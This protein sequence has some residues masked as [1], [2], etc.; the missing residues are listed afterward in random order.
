MIF[1]P[2]AVRVGVGYHFQG[3]TFR[4]NTYFFSNSLRTLPLARRSIFWRSDLLSCSYIYAIFLCDNDIRSHGLSSNRDIS[5][6]DRRQ[7][8]FAARITSRHLIHDEKAVPQQLAES[9]LN[10][11]WSVT[12]CQPGM[13][14]A[15]SCRIMIEKPVD[16][17]DRCRTEASRH[18]ADR[19]RLRAAPGATSGVE[20]A[21]ARSGAGCDLFAAMHQTL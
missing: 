1:T 6:A 20:R 13:K 21:G 18:A 10:R 2:F 12:R 9:D 16:D 5:I 7:G 8:Q 19:H 11:V 15:Q 17:I 3:D 14:R 4:A